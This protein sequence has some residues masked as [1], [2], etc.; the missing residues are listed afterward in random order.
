MASLTVPTSHSSVQNRQIPSYASTRRWPR[1]HMSVS[2]SKDNAL[3]TAK[4]AS[5][6]LLSNIEAKDW[7]S[8]TIAIYAKQIWQSTTR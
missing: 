4:R 2:L 5:M 6:D 1:T 8:T 7:T 3:P